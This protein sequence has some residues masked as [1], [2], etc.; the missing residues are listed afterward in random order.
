MNIK[1]H[2]DIFSEEE[3][4]LTITGNRLSNIKPKI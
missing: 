2:S 1:K 3:K 4:E